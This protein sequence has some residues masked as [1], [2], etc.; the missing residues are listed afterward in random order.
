MQGGFCQ[1]R[2]STFLY[3]GTRTVLYVWEDRAWDPD[4]ANSPKKVAFRQDYHREEIYALQE[5]K[6]EIR[7]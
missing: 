4:W 5:V 3:E 7:P 2:K 1:S 6:W